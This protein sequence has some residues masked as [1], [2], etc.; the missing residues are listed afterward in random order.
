MQ[1]KDPFFH[2]F[3]TSIEG[4]MLPSEF[5]YPFN[6]IPHPLSKIASKELQQYLVSQKEWLFKSNTKNNV[7]SP[8]HGKMFGVLVVKNQQNE[9]GYLT[10]FSGNEKPANQ[11]SQFVPPVY[12]YS[13]ENSY[14]KK[15]NTEIISINQ[16]IKTLINAEEYSYL[17]KSLATLEQ[18]SLEFIGRQKE[19]IK[20][21]KVKRDELKTLLKTK[22]SEEE[23]EKLLARLKHESY[24]EHTLL[25]EKKRAQKVIILEASEKLNKYEEKINL[26]KKERKKRSIALQHWLFEQY[27]FL[28]AEGTSK[29]LLDIFNKT[30]GEDPP[31]GSGECAAPKLLHYA[32]KRRYTLIS[33]AEFWWGDS[34]IKEVRKQGYFYP[35]CRSRCKPILS[36]MLKG[37]TIEKHPNELKNFEEKQLDILYNDEHLVVIS[38]PHD[39]LSVEGK[40]IKECVQSKIKRMFPEATG[41]MMVHRLDMATSG[42]MVIAKTENSYLKLQQQFINRTIQKRYIA[43]LEG[44]ISSKKGVIELPLRVDLDDRPR[45]LVCNEYG[46]Y[47]KTEWEV[48]SHKEKQ[49]LIHFYPITGRTH[50][51][52]VH[53][54]HSKGLNTPIVGDDLYGQKAERLHLHAEYLQFIHPSTN[55]KME[56]EVKADFSS[57]S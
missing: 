36:H 48:I 38:K 17:K 34:T 42:I 2:S 25:K 19:S 53:A 11:D 32:Y 28:N 23:F 26:L 13:S 14:F 46:R 18:N 4:I 16:K 43:L 3:N 54:A 20:K 45:Q 10:A 7:E 30:L 15:E 51:L 33:L 37:L 35:S 12:D 27:S 56:F 24:L 29:S 5:T 57:L 9:L 50:Q 49:T 40:E 44:V 21:N 22:I 41:P 52:R 8:V 31:S 1:S 6:Y 55:Q 47:A 39:L